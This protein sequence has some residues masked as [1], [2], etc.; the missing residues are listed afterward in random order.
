M[1]KSSNFF[2]LII[3]LFLLSCEETCC[4]IEYTQLAQGDQI[5]YLLQKYELK[6]NNVLTVEKTE[7]NSYR[8]KSKLNRYATSYFVFNEGYLEN[9]REEKVNG[10]RYQIMETSSHWDANNRLPQ[11]YTY[12]RNGQVQYKDSLIYDNQDRMV[13]AYSLSGV[14]DLIYDEDNKLT[15]KSYT[16]NGAKQWTTKFLYDGRELEREEFYMHK[17][18]EPVMSLMSRFRENETTQYNIKNGEEE[19]DRTITVNKYGD[20]L[21]TTGKYGVTRDLSYEYDPR[22]NWVLRVDMSKEGQYYATHREITYEDGT[23]TGDEWTPEK[24]AEKLD[25]TYDKAAYDAYRAE[26]NSKRPKS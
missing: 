5:P 8:D 26:L 21:K 2:V 14:L 16:R 25:L 17:T 6:N 24:I 4:Q 20:D 7:Y 19:L 18:G 12:L 11:E 23:V 9:F 3:T 15:E 22:G 13:K 1:I 10:G